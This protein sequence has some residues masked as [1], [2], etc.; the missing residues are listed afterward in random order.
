MGQT[1]VEIL[2]RADALLAE[3]AAAIPGGPRQY[4]V[5]A[6]DERRL[7][8]L[9]LDEPYEGDDV[10]KMG[11]SKMAASAKAVAN[12]AAEGVPWA[13]QFVFER[14]FGKPKQVVQSTNLNM[15]LKEYLQQLAN[16]PQDANIV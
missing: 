7:L 4:P 10:S 6:I 1:N 2:T 12:Q 15:T 16:S 9:A 3:Q 11:L 5:I 13:T 8:Q 14:L